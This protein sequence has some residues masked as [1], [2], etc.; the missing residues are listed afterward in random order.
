MSLRETRQFLTSQYQEVKEIYEGL[1]D[2][3]W[4][5]L[6]WGQKLEEVKEELDN[7]PVDVVEPKMKLLFSG[8]V[9]K[10]SKGIKPSFLSKITPSILEIIK[11]TEISIKKEFSPGSKKIKSKSDLYLTSLPVGSFG[12][13]LTQLD[14]EDF[15]G[16]TFT[17][18]GR[19]MVNT[20]ETLEEI[21]SNKK[22]VNE[23]LK[24]KSKKYIT[25]LK[26]LTTEMA[27]T[28]SILKIESGSYFA[29][30][31]NESI[32]LASAKISNIE[33]KEESIIIDGTL[34]GFFLESMKFEI[35]DIEGRKIIGK[36][37]E[38]LDEKVL[39]EFLDKFINEKCSIQLTEH[40][41]HLLHGVTT[42]SYILNSVS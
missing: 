29:E 27:K 28:N 30:V 26:T 7:L 35:T 9:V 34:K 3:P 14:G 2:D 31:S 40:T 6:S 18:I 24:N 21:F 37:S 16:H 8:N 12:I 19:S 33:V 17:D 13:E 25:N 41:K 22:D 15:F 20:I 5:S 11:Q 4:M 1:K 39:I 38:D 32:K 36:I 10:G 42:V 23:I